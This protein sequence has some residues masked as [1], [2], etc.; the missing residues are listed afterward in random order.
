[1]EDDEEI[2]T[3]LIPVFEEALSDKEIHKLADSLK[4]KKFVLQ[5]TFKKKR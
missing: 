1:M 4:K 5:G 3:G 2:L